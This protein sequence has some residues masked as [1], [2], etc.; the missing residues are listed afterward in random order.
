MTL[1]GLVLFA[2]GFALTVYSISASQSTDTASGGP[3]D[4]T[5]QKALEVGTRS[6]T[7]VVVGLAVGMA[8]IVIA[9]VGPTLGALGGGSRST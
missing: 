1:V 2:S 4:S 8:G 6:D 5:V 3:S 7:L 9:T